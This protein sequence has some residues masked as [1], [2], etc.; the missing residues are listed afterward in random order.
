MAPTPLNLSK[1]R[2]ADLERHIVGLKDKKFD[3]LPDKY[4]CY[5]PEYVGFHSRRFAVL[6]T[7]LES[8]GTTQESKLL[9]VGPTFTSILFHHHFNCTVDSLSFSPD[10]TTPFGT[11]YEFDLNRSQ[12]KETW[13]TDLGGY[14]AVVFAEVIEHLYTAPS[15]ALEYLKSLVKPGGY[16]LVQTP[17]ALGIKQRL[18]LLAGKHPYEEINPDPNSPNHFR[19][20]TLAELV[21]YSQ[22]AGLEVVHAAHYNYFNPT[23]RQKNKRIRPWMGALFFRISDFLPSRLKRGMTVVCRRPLTP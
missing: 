9:D 14:D 5:S 7:I 4:V 16:I 3:G 10:E 21:R 13:R 8:L 6:L 2:I 18:Q 1:S 20:S 23:F 17:N 22:G 15:V 19:E 12:R 11:N